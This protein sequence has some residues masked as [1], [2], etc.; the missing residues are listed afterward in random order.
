MISCVVKFSIP[1]IQYHKE[2]LIHSFP[3]RRKGKWWGPGDVGCDLW[4]AWKR[5]TP[6]LCVEECPE[7]QGFP[8]PVFSPPFLHLILAK[9]QEMIFLFLKEGF[10]KDP[11]QSNL[12]CF[13]KKISNYFWILILFSYCFHCW[14][15]ISCTNK[16][17]QTLQVVS[18]YHHNSKQCSSFSLV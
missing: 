6:G 12:R 7:W 11:T 10:R 8:T 13:P 2:V 16:M 9:G 1:R 17:C 18:C 5:N 15:W 3:F 4:T 14:H